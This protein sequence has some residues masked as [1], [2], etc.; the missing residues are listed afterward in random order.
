MTNPPIPLPQMPARRV[1]AVG[2]V[3]RTADG[4][5]IT[6][7]VSDAGVRFTPARRAR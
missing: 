2:S 4:R 6:A 5:T 1:L 3:R 7:T